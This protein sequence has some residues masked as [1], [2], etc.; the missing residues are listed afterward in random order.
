MSN[1]ETNGEI[2]TI[3]SSNYM[4]AS[5]SVRTYGGQRVDRAISDEVH[6]AHGATA[7][8]GKYVR[9]MFGENNKRIKQVSG[10]YNLMRNFL[11][12]RTLCWVS[13]TSGAAQGDR[14]L[15]VSDSLDFIR[16]FAVR[17]DAAKVLRD[18]VAAELPSII[19]NARASM[20]N[21]APALEDYPTQD[22]FKRYFD[23]QMTVTP[24][25]TDS[26]FSRMSV[27]PKVAEGL[28][29]M[30]QKRMAK[31]LENAKQE[32]VDRAVSKLQVMSVQLT[33]EAHGGKTRMFNTMLA[34]V[35]REVGLLDAIAS[36]TDGSSTGIGAAAKYCHDNIT[37]K[38]VD[39][40]VFKGNA[41][42]SAEVASK[43]NTAIAMLTGKDAPADVKQ[44]PGETSNQ[45]T[46]SAPKVD[47]TADV[48]ATLAGMTG[49]SSPPPAPK[50]KPA[51]TMSISNMGDGIVEPAAKPKEEDR[52]V[53]HESG[54]SSFDFD[55]DDFLS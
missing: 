47:D 50:P 15:P 13:E 29:V 55:P 11:Y 26:D 19:T 34:N 46:Q 18:E 23:V 4:L 45:S 43:A 44:S 31:Q 38:Y 3:V 53:T 28:Q 36:T 8:T 5:V 16:D 41:A 12:S 52:E 25:P 27:P 20:G 21:M 24:I 30:Y 39:V 17:R 14:L 48:L 37:S 49:D 33:K 54:A 6:T 35:S 1:K 42:L 2:G 22:E 51:N 10:A 40:S 32:A 9:N 7:A